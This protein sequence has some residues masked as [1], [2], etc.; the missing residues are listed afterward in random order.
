[1]MRTP[2]KILGITAAL[3]AMILYACSKYKDPPNANPVETGRH[4]C[5]DSRAINYNWG[6]PGTPDNDT[7]VYPVDS[8]LGNWKFTDSIFLPN[9]NLQE[10]TTR[11]LNF[12]ST[13]DTVFR[14][15]AV[16]GWCSGA[17][18]HITVD[19]YSF[20]YTD[21]LI[22]GAYGQLLCAVTDTV[23]GNFKKREAQRDTMDI[24]LTLSAPEGVT[25]H[26]GIALRQ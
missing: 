7:C 16:S 9:G 5:N 23:T 4:Y 14:H 18:I 15:M 17:P 12:T 2:T 6:F 10:V 20:A 26:K 22:E 11:N 19:K 24:D 3:S 1:M 13:E 25:R 21:T 8:M